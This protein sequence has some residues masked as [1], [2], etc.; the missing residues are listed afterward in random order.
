MSVKITFLGTGDASNSGG[1]AQQAILLTT[2]DLTLLVDCGANT[3]QRLQ[4]MQINPNEIDAV[5]FTH[6]HADHFLGTVH[7]DLS[8]IFDFP[9]KRNLLYLGP[10]GLKQRCEQLFSL[11]YP[12]LYPNDN[13]VREMVE[14]EPNQKYVVLDNRAI[15]ET[16]PMEHAPESLGYRIFLNG[17]YIAITGD[18]QWHD[19]IIDLA[20]NSDCLICECF[21]YKKPQPR[22][23][24]CSYEEISENSDRIDTKKII[25]LHAHREVL[26]HKDN[27]DFTI[28]NDGEV[29]EIE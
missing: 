6:F 5:L 7:L 15:I 29:I 17:K 27:I 4:Q 9:R 25:L 23:G 24:H 26:A 3:L 1:R 13:F 20:K 19:G 18:T 21:H 14:Y 22:I 12:R 28:A 11:S 10:V 8:L 16:F 2:P